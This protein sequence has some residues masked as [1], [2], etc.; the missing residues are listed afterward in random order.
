VKAVLVNQIGQLLVGSA[1]GVLQAL[2]PGSTGQV[3][4]ADTAQALKVKW[5]APPA[6]TAPP[7]S[8]ADFIV[9]RSGS[10]WYARDNRTGLTFT[11]NADFATVVNT[12]SATFVDPDA[13][14]TLNDGGSIFIA[15]P[16]NA[17]SYVVNGGIQVTT[18]ILMRTGMSLFAEGKATRLIASGVGM[19]NVPVI[20]SRD[21]NRVIVDNFAIDCNAVLGC[22]GVLANPSDSGVDPGTGGPNAYNLIT[23]LDISNFTPDTAYPLASDFTSTDPRRGGEGIMLGQWG[24]TGGT[25]NTWSSMN[26]VYGGGAGSINCGVHVGDA[27]VFW[28]NFHH[29]NTSNG[30]GVFIDAG[31]INLRFNHVAQSGVGSPNGSIYANSGAGI[32]IFGNYLDNVFDGAAVIIKPASGASIGS[33]QIIGNSVNGLMTTDAAIPFVKVDVSAGGTT[34]NGTIMDNVGSGTDG[35]H[36]FS[37]IVA[38]PASTETWYK[39]ANNKLRYTKQIYTGLKPFDLGRNDIQPTSA[40]SSNLML[41]DGIGSVLEATVEWANTAIEQ[42][43]LTYLIPADTMDV[44]TTYSFELYGSSDNIASSGPFEWRVKVGGVIVASVQFPDQAGAQT[45][46]EWTARGLM[47]CQAKGAG[48][49]CSAAIDVRTEFAADQ[50]MN[51]TVA[52]IDTTANRVLSIAIDMDTAAAGNAIRAKMGKIRL[53]K[54]AN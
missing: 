20:Q 35:T 41:E 40:S 29:I 45:G 11:S 16:S 33:P 48:G 51:C 5:A 15:R 46:K 49:S 44:G 42:D 10:T 36:R 4:T 19:K 47:T 54:V 39:V 53:E 25:T 2:N 34:S 9:Y 22:S 37:A 31:G 50:K 7:F 27:Q 24:D 12:C 38:M 52:A 21:K 3:L 18:P 43:L 6:A 1:V 8:L 13:G 32:K 17:D 23:R 28:N 30:F 14:Q 26:H